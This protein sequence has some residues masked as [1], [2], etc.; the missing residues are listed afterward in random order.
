MKKETTDKIVLVSNFTSTLDIFEKLCND[1]RYVPS[2][3]PR[4]C[5][6]VCCDRYGWLRLDGTMNPT[7]RQKLVDKFNDPDGKELVFLLSS[8]AGGCGINLIGANRLILF[9]P[10]ASS[11]LLEW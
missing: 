2:S 9:D 5:S 11:F 6:I 1:R 8:K 3:S 7:K 4:R 10:G